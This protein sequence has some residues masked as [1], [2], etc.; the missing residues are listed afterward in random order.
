MRIKT[1][2]KYIE[3][4]YPKEKYPSFQKVKPQLEEGISNI[5]EKNSKFEITG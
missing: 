5:L 2:I 4:M 1:L 3:S